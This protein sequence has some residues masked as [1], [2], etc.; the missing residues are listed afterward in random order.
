MACSSQPHTFCGNLL[1]SNK[2]HTLE[3]LWRVAQDQ[4]LPQMATYS[5]HCN[6]QQHVKLSARIQS[7]FSY[8][9]GT[10]KSNAGQATSVAETNL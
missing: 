1:L 2:A 5:G 9:M 10:A 6:L 8:M 7:V 4:Q 3:Q